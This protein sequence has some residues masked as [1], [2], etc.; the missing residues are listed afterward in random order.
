M[1]QKT[2]PPKKPQKKSTGK[3]S[4]FAFQLTRKEL[5]LWLGVAF[6][7]MVWMF[8]LGVIVGRG[9]SPVR[10]D[11][12]KLKKEL[13]A[14]KEDALTE[15]EG[16]NKPG[17]NAT[18]DKRHLGFYDVLTDKKEEARLKSLPKAPPTAKREIA[19]RP[20]SKNQQEVSEANKQK[21]SSAKGETPAKSF[22]LQVASLKDSGRAKKLVSDLKSKGYGAYAVTARVKGKGTY[23]R[24]RVGHFKDLNEARKMAARLRHEKFEPIV[25]RE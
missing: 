12:E 23:Y 4:R 21:P 17:V 14:L 25:I 6:L 16:A 19:R 15:E 1:S 18:P 5:F 10:F 2:T 11:V 20:E 24:V 13:L 7:A 22:T 8:T 3:K 9:I